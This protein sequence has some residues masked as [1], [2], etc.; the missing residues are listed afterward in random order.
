MVLMK[1]V[2]IDVLPSSAKA[3]TLPTPLRA[4]KARKLALKTIQ[5]ALLLGALV[6]F[7]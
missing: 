6:A 7:L 1:V 4:K 2:A 3:L 5:R